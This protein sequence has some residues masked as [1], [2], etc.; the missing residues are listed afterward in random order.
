M[1]RRILGVSESATGKEWVSCGNE[2]IEEGRKFAQHYGLQEMLGTIMASRGVSYND[3]EQY[4][5]PRIKD[6]LPD[7]YTLT[8][9]EL[10]VRRFSSAILKEETIALFGDYDVDG[11]S[12]VALMLLWMRSVGREPTVYIPDRIKEG[13]GPTPVSMR[14]LSERHDLIVTLDC[15]TVACMEIHEATKNNTDV[16]VIDHHITTRNIPECSAVVN[17]NRYDD[18]S[19]LGYLCAAGVTFLFLIA[20]N[21]YMREHNHFNLLGCA[22]PNLMQML[23]IVALATVSDVVPLE[24]V[25]RSFIRQGIRIMSQGRNKGIKALADLANVSLSELTEH[26]I[27][28]A[29]APRINA[30]GRVWCENA[31]LG[32]QLLA[33]DDD[34]CAMRIAEDMNRC[35]EERKEIERHVMMQAIEQASEQMQ[36]SENGIIV[37]IGK[38]WHE[39]VIGIIAGRLSERFVRP[40]LVISVNSS[41]IGKGSGRSVP[42]F[43]FSDV[44]ARCL[45]EGIII[46]GGGHSMAVGLSVY[47]SMIDKLSARCNQL[48]NSSTGIPTVPH[49]YIDICLSPKVDVQSI[50]ENLRKIAPYGSNFPVPVVAIV[51]G[52]VEAVNHFGEGH[53]RIFV[54]SGNANCNK[55]LECIS[56]RAN[57]T[58]LGDCLC[59][60]RRKHVH[61]AGYLD[62]NTWG[63][64]S[65]PQLIIKDVSSV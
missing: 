50:V 38:E 58:A 18:D 19:T 56:F 13:Y 33:T 57:G 43:N 64:R 47:E 34:A 44:I 39:G 45:E 59:D 7:P 30:V 17:P 62:I 60:L 20:L 21:R 63:G 2:I 55:R 9:M 52:Y 35:N 12:S 37:A 48:F 8:D 41:G 10:A 29:F 3:V 42:G 61:I 1:Y 4:L 32:V 27:G 36:K 6:L 22:E 65:K 28:F 16:I 46:H 26:H 15:G 40:S 54:S 31:N 11:V 51:N 49:L 14:T 25:N 5:N 24:G 53:I 23:D